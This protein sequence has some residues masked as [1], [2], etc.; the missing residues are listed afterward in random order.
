MQSITTEDNSEA[1]DVDDDLDMDRAA[2]LLLQSTPYSPVPSQLRGGKIPIKRECI[3]G[4]LVEV[5]D[6]TVEEDGVSLIA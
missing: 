3:N 2:P 6:L 5:I 1:M 4:R